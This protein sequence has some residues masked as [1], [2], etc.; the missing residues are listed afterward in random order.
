MAEHE[1][2]LRAGDTFI[3]SVRNVMASQQNSFSRNFRGKNN[4]IIK[5]L[6][7]IIRLF[8]ETPFKLLLG[9]Y[10]QLRFGAE[11]LNK[12]VNSFLCLDSS[13]KL[14]GEP[15]RKNLPKKLNTALVFPPIGKG[16]SPFPI[17]EMIS[18]SNKTIDFI[19]FFQYAWHNMG[20]TVNDQRVK[21]PAVIVSDI[22]WANVHS[23][24]DFFMKETIKYYLINMFGSLTKGE[25]HKYTT[26]LAICENHL[27]P[28]LLKSAREM[29]QN[30]VLA[31]TTV[32][33]VMLML[34][35]ANFTSAVEIWNNL[36]KI[37]CSKNVDKVAQECVKAYSALTFTED[38]DLENL[39]IQEFLSNSDDP[40][41]IVRYGKKEAI[42]ANSPFFNF[43]MKAIEKIESLENNIDAV[44]NPYWCPKLL[45]M[46]C[47]QYLS[48]YP[49]FSACVLPDSICGLRNNSYVELYW[50]ESKR[51]LKNVPKRLLWPP[52]YL[53]TMFENI[54]NRATELHTKKFIPNVR[55]GGKVK[56]KK[57]VSFIQQ[58]DQQVFGYRKGSK[59]SRMKI[60]ITNLTNSWNI[61][62]L[63][64][65]KVGDRT[66]I[67]IHLEIYPFKV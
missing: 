65:L 7:G 12:T 28:A 15:Q 51:I 23:I 5:K 45:K 26:V 8:Q 29:M 3:E 11:Y 35:A 53:G 17:F 39:L 10:D 38:E 41:D 67:S 36:V 42:R 16:E 52:T 64:R 49:L 13:G 60:Y 20:K 55:T 54:Q 43:F 58:M 22:S 61:R 59:V 63:K 66:Q 1:K 44:K 27:R 24:L 14:W 37:H 18:E 21:Y 40:D 9:C 34:Q 62:K 50:E 31:D 56:E 30:K 25:D 19:I 47:K 32:A 33:G 48:L 6:P 46:I 57:T 2:R 4:E